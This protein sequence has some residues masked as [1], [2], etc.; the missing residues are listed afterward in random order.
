M[1]FKGAGIGSSYDFITNIV[2]NCQIINENIILKSIDIS[3]V[4]VMRGAPTSIG[5]F[6][7]TKSFILMTLAWLL[8]E[9]KQ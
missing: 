1:D 7:S 5:M 9:V 8:N 3:C 2:E 4:K 6:S